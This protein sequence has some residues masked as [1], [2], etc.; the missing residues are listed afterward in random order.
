MDRIPKDLELL[1]KY[2]NAGWGVRRLMKWN[3]NLK[4]K[5]DENAR[6]TRAETEERTPSDTQAGEVCGDREDLS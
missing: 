4:R 5:D 6:T 1:I 3:T 2:P